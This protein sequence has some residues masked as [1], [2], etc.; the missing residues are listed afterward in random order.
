MSARRK[1]QQGFT[2]IELIAVVVLLGV[3]GAATTQYLSQSVRIYV[4][5]AR[6]DS[7]Q[8]MG[9]FAVERVAREVRN[10]L[11]GSVRVETDVDINGRKTCLEYVPIE[12]ASSYLGTVADFQRTSLQAVD[13]AYPDAAV[14]NRRVA[15]YTIDERD[16]YIYSRK[17]VVD[18][19][20]VDAVASSQRTVNFKNFSGV[21]HR[22]RS[23]SPTR[24]FYI[25]SQP[26]SFCVRNTQL[27]RH[28]NYGWLN[29]QSTDTTDIGTGILL[30]ESIQQADGADVVDVFA[31]TE[32][33]LQRAGIV[34]LDFRFMDSSASDEWVRFSQ[35]VAVRNAQ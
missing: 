9:R 3:L 16:V 20:N 28:A 12:A 5:S 2:L 8:Q 30:A 17:A 32:G 15:I 7:L 29:N 11:P 14:N 35:D 4:D 24:R 23:E 19:D 22:F 6:R 34:H 18:L 13:F 31:Y 26:V 25:V 33:A 21:G 27:Y 1:S 10:A